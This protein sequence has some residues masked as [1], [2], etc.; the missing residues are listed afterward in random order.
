MRF[1]ENILN[2]PKEQCPRCLGKGEVSLDDIKRLKKELYW[3]PGSCAYCNGKGKVS[4]KMV[5]N[6]APDYVYLTHDLS[7]DERKRIVS[8]DRNALARGEQFQNQTEHQITEIKFLYFV[9]KLDI[10]TIIN[11]YFLNIQ[12]ETAKADFRTFVEMVLQK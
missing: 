11:F 9:A 1:L 6:V 2:P 5:Q 4:R 12:D 7:D 8:R 10:E 3:L